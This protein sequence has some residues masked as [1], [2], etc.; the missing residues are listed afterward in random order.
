M[1]GGGGPVPAKAD[2]AGAEVELVQMPGRETVLKGTLEKV[3]HLYDLILL[4]CPPALGL[5][6][7]NALVAASTVLVPVQC[8]YYAME[9]LGRLMDNV[10]RV[11]HSFNPRLEVEGILLTMYLTPSPE[12]RASRTQSDTPGAEPKEDRLPQTRYRDAPPGR[13][14]SHLGEDRTGHKPSAP[15]GDIFLYRHTST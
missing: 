14:Q 1:S 9:G 12:N 3:E 2:L 5:L 6:T 11:R 13:G 8:E 10:Q 15:P 7:I 4:D